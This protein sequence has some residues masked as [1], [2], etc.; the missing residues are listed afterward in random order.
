M[1][2]IM[3]QNTFLE[4]PKK[5]DNSKKIDNLQIL[6]SF[7]TLFSF[8]IDHEY[9]P[10]MLLVFN[11][12]FQVYGRITVATVALQTQAVRLWY[13]TVVFEID[14]NR[15]A[16]LIRPTDNVFE[17]YLITVVIFFPLI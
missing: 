6:S 2:Q 15:I 5:I 16:F 7:L 11:S 8:W 9:Y 1:V 4:N 17:L 12:I 13:V 10:L 3:N 14:Q